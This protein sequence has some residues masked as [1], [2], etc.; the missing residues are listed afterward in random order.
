[1][2]LQP[3]AI[4]QF[5]LEQQI[6]SIGAVAVFAGQ[7]GMGPWQSEEVYAF[8]QEFIRRKCPV[9]PVMLPETLTQPRLPIFLKNRHWVDFRLREPEPYSQLIWGI[10]G[11]RPNGESL[12]VAETVSV[13]KTEQFSDIALS[14]LDTK[15]AD[16]ER[17]LKS[18]QWKEANDETHR[19][20][21]TEVGKR[22]GQWLYDNELLSFPCEPLKVIDGL[23]VQHSGGKFGFSVQKKLYLDCGGLADRRY[24][25][26]VWDKFCE[27]NGWSRDKKKNAF[28]RYDTSSPSGHLPAIGTGDQS[29]WRGDRYA[30]YHYVAAL[31]NL[32][33]GT[34]KL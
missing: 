24:E 23:W 28:I 13:R 12:N 7:K 6:E 22:K 30:L 34:C 32:F 17:Y 33:S 14:V 26:E 27:A 2:E 21:I 3:G 16:L 9:I 10:T 19:L 15:Y 31:N 25:P 1:M 20:M 29:S 18:G 4:W 5:A 8:L 11:E